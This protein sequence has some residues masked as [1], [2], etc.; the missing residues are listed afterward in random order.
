MV[1]ANHSAGP[2]ELD[3][4]ADDGALAAPLPAVSA[5]DLAAMAMEAA[6]FLK[7]FSHDGR[8]MIL[9]F[10]VGGPRS[11]GELEA[12]LS[13]RQAA[14]SQQLARLRMEGLVNA[15]RE[16]QT[17]YYSIRDP[18]VYDILKVLKG[19]FC[20]PDAPKPRP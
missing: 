2:P 3:A 6:N 5:E 18:R 13:S 11:V 15:R 1:A 7:A 8:L 20:P 16:G 4:S 9:C 12:L 17:I 10:L 14:V 19:I